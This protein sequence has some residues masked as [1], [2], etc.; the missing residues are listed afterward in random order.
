MILPFSAAVVFFL[1][2]LNLKS[3]QN[4]SYI[5]GYQINKLYICINKNAT[6]TLTPV[7]KKIKNERTLYC[8]TVNWGFS[9]RIS[10]RIQ[11]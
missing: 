8:K 3:T 7:A 10:Y 9:P 6:G 4:A 11:N 1:R 2:S 5:F